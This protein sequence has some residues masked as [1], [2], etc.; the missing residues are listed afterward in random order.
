M[1]SRQCAAAPADSTASMT[2]SSSSARPAAQPAANAR[3][4]AELDRGLRPAL[5]QGAGRRDDR[6]RG[7]DGEQRVPGADHEQVGLGAVEHMARDPGQP[8]AGRGH[9]AAEH[10]RG[11][12]RARR[13]AGQ[14]LGRPAVAGYRTALAEH[15]AGQSGRQVGRRQQ[16]PPGL[17]DR[18]GDLGQAGA[19]PAV[20]LGN[21]EPGEP[22]LSGEPVPG[23]GAGVLAAEVAYRL[24]Q[25]GLFGVSIRY[26]LGRPSPRSATMFRW[27]SFDPPKIVSARA[28]RNSRCVSVRP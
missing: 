16:H 5:V 19:R 12:Q 8:A 26:P 25:G 13:D 24:A 1:T 7:P 28:N 23:P 14:E 17:L 9:R 11:A 27:I 22:E 2:R 6:V 15:R 18:D 10:E 4:I 20:A 3:S 21:R